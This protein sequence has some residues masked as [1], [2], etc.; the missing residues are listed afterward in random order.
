M[1]P[2]FRLEIPFGKELIKFD[3]VGLQQTNPSVKG[4]IKLEH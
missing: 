1:V 4:P 2:L 3:F